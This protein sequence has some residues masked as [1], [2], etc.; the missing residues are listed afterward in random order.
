MGVSGKPVLPKL[1]AVIEYVQRGLH[2]PDSHS[3]CVDGTIRLERQQE[4]AWCVLN[5]EIALDE[6]V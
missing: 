5:R 6:V 3:C 1:G 4:V 2:A